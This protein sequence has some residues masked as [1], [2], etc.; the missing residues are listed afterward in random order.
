MSTIRAIA[1]AARV[2]I[3]TVSNFLND[4]DLVAADTRERIERVIE[5]LDYRPRAAARSLRS[6]ATRRIGLI[7]VVSLTDNRGAEPGDNAFLELLSGL[8]TVAAESGYDILISAAIDADQELEAYKR[9]VGEG[10]V[11]GLVVMGIRSQDE[12]LRF[13]RAKKFPFV[14]FGRSDILMPYPYVDVDGA[15]GVAEAIDHLAELGHMRIAYITPPPILMCTRQRWEGFERGM[16]RNGLAIR[17]Q[18][19]V[20]GDFGEASG[21]AGAEL[22]L[23]LPEPPT[24]ILT[25]ND[26]SAFGVMRILHSRELA[27]GRDVSVIGFDDVGIASHWQ[28]ALTTIA[29]PFRRIG[30]LLMQSLLSVLSGANVNPQKVIDTRLVVRSSTGPPPR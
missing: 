30:F 21:A 18:Y 12:R 25:A 7:P 2:S 13:L 1:K 8:N 27:T 3:G 17:D 9:V 14:A 19:I 15:S 23:A 4:P 22:L 5:D 29:Q 20:Q 26:V 11:D 6:R 10:Q 28:P 16:E 24:A